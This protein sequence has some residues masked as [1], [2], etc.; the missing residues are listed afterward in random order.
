[1]ERVK[2]REGTGSSDERQQARDEPQGSAW[3]LD[4]SNEVHIPADPLVNASGSSLSAM[5]FIK[6]LAQSHCCRP[7]WPPAT[8][9][10]RVQITLIKEGRW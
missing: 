2:R 6:P 3:A 8:K 7:S 10:A 1:M 4:R 9:Q 5:S